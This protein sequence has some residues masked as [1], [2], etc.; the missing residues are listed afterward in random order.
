[1]SDTEKTTNSAEFLL[2][3]FNALQE[4]AVSYEE[5]K[6]S[7][8]NFYLVVVAAALA[9]FPA[10][11]EHA[12]ISLHGGLAILASLI[13][14]LGLVTLDQIVEY[15]IAITAFYRAAGRVRVWHVEQNPDI[16]P[17]VAFSPRDDR[18]AIRVK[19]RAQVFRGADATVLVTS[20]VALATLVVS[21]LR[22]WY[23][24]QWWV[25]IPTGVMVAFAA[26]Y[27]QK[28]YIYMKLRRADLRKRNEIHFPIST[29][30]RAAYSR[31]SIVDSVSA[32]A[33]KSPETNSKSTK[34]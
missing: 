17:Y 1:M 29:S 14:V 2:A 23:I 6:S 15:S 27:L 26:W 24:M 5:I 21:L 31:I 7:R 32:P 9:S 25:W 4:R 20:S 22:H 19:F 10:L 34:S 8:V 33:D 30:L 3:E 28:G 18:P 16:A 11:I 12:Q 13:L